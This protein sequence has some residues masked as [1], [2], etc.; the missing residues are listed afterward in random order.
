MYN[1]KP[2]SKF[3]QRM[4]GI[5]I[6]ADKQERLTLSAEL[7]R[8]LAYQSGEAFYLYFDAELRTIGLSKQPAGQDHIPYSFDKRGYTQ[9]KD[10]LRQCG[11]DTS[12]EAVKFIY[13]GEFDGILAFRQAGF[14]WSSSFRMERNGNLERV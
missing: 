3:D 14:R 12:S 10:F 8:M 4:S 7:Q 5:R 6:T 2:I 1:F 9:A 11:I 13:E